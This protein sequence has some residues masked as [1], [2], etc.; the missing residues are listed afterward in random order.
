[1]RYDTVGVDIRVTSDRMILLD[2]QP[3][4]SS[5]VLDWFNKTDRMPPP[6][7]KYA[8]NWVE[9]QVCA[10]LINSFLIFNSLPWKQ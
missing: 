5:S 10:S 2:T 7:I 1:M 9:M 3:V 6:D 8:E 4:L